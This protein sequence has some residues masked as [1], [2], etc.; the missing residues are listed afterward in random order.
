MLSE[1]IGITTKHVLDDADR[2]ALTWYQE[3]DVTD[4]LRNI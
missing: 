3:L 1:R 2:T 4:L